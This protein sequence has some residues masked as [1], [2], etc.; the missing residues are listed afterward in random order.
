MFVAEPVLLDTTANA[1]PALVAR[2]GRAPAH[3][4]ASSVLRRLASA[5]QLLAWHRSQRPMVGHKTVSARAWRRQ[6][7]LICLQ[8]DLEI[9]ARR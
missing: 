3:Q 7:A 9:E 2:A 1:R 5:H 4:A 8:A 6:S